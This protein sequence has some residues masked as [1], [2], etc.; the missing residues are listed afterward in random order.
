[1]R[2]QTIQPQPKT[3]REQK[4]CNCARCEKELTSTFVNGVRTTTDV[5][6]RIAGRPYCETCFSIARLEHSGMRAA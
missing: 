4:A 6:G 3:R 1:M 5:A 2:R